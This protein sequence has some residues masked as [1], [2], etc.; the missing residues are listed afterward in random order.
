MLV[1]GSRVSSPKEA[2]AFHPTKDIIPK[3]MPR[4]TPPIP[5]PVAGLKTERVPLG[6]ALEDHGEQ[7]DGD[8]DD[9]VDEKDEPPRTD[10]V[11]PSTESV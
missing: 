6:P 4:N 5:L 1:C 7:Q 9:L 10:W 8:D 3:I 11:T 2:A